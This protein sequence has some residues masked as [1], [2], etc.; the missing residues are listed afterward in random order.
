MNDWQARAACRGMSWRLFFPDSPN[1]Y[2]N[3][4]LA[5]EAKQ[6]CAACPVLGECAEAGRTERWG[7]WAGVNRG[8]KQ[9]RSDEPPAWQKPRSLQCE[10]C[11]KFWRWSPAAGCK[12]PKACSSFCRNRLISK[13]QVRSHKLRQVG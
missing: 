9:E 3:K 1:A 13:S 5:A 6:V 4:R 7:I 2:E 8:P 11:G 12:P 10:V